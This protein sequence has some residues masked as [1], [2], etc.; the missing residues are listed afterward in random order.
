VRPDSHAG[1]RGWSQPDD[2]EPLE[3]IEYQPPAAER[4]EPFRALLGSDDPAPE[5]DYGPPDG[6]PTGAAELWRVAEE[7]ASVGGAATASSGMPEAIV[8]SWPASE[9][10][11]SF[12]HRHDGT[13]Y[14]FVL[15]DPISQ[16]KPLTHA[17]R[18]V[19]RCPA[20]DQVA[21]ILR[22]AR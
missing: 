2:A 12:A 14:R 17:D 8:A 9:P 7:H 13:V 6:D 15:V 1:D 5:A 3:E 19:L 10:V 18:V 21:L 20:C 11:P 22:Q 4:E 16:G